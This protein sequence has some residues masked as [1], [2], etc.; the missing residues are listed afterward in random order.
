M[1]QTYLYHSFGTRGSRVTARSSRLRAWLILQFLISASTYLIQSSAVCQQLR[2][3]QKTQLEIRTGVIGMN[4]EGALEDGPG[5]RKLFLL[6]LPLGVLEP[7]GEAYAVAA[8]VVLK[9]AALPALVLLQ[10]LEV[11]KPLGGFL[12]GRLLAVDGFAQQL[13]SRNLHWRRRLV[14]DPGW[15]ARRLHFV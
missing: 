7:V 6:E 11:G 10:L 14:L 12:D 1:T 2:P 3:G 9:L 13:F 4:I 15:S 8:N 5:A